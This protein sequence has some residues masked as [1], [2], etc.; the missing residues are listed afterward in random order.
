MISSFLTIENYNRRRIREKLYAEVLDK[1]EAMGNLLVSSTEEVSAKG[2]PGLRYPFQELLLLN[3]KVVE[4]V[5]RLIFELDPPCSERASL[6]ET[7][8]DLSTML[9]KPRGIRVY[10]VG[11]EESLNVTSTVGYVFYKIAIE[12]LVNISKHSS[13]SRAA[14]VIQNIGHEYSLEINDDG[15]G[16]NP[17]LLKGSDSHRSFGLAIMNSWINCIGGHLFVD[18]KEGE[19][20]RVI[21]KVNVKHR[22]QELDWMNEGDATEFSRRLPESRYSMHVEI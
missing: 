5:S 2:L 14:I 7:M 20:T 8:R 22:D 21:A 12:A 4:S 9:L 11:N 19:G 6:L 13:A 1:L 16:F 18:S 3:S 15:V 17:T 10:V